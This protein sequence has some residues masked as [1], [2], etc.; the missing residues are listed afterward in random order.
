MFSQEICKVDQRRI[1]DISFYTYYLSCLTISAFILLGVGGFILLQL[2]VIENLFLTIFFVILLYYTNL[3]F[4]GFLYPNKNVKLYSEYFFIF[5][6]IIIFLHKIII[7][8]MG[9]LGGFF[10]NGMY[11]SISI[12]CLSPFIV[13]HSI[14]CNFNK[15]SFLNS[16]KIGSLVYIMEALFHLLLLIMHKKIL[17]A[18]SLKFVYF[19][20]EKPINYTLN[21]LLVFQVLYYIAYLASVLFFWITFPKA[22]GFI[23]RFYNRHN[24][25]FR[26]LHIITAIIGVGVAVLLIIFS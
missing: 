19:T 6:I 10:V 26:F 16:M 2:G 25:L 13:K 5:L 8:F 24:L 21:Q 7:S 4:M 12:L 18:D 15:A 9:A 3:I 11:F 17:G 23:I 14:D 22:Q 20:S 1:N